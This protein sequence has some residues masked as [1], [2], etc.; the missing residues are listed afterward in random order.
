MP[1]ARYLC[2]SIDSDLR[3]ILIE[4]L[5]GQREMLRRLAVIE[6]EQRR[7]FSHMSD[8]LDRLNREVGEMRDAVNTAGTKI[9]E[10]SAE[11][12][13]LSDIVAAGGTVTDADLNAVSDQLDQMQTDLAAA[14]LPPAATTEPEPTA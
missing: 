1:D 11:I 5:G 4:F 9:G 8:A 10:Q 6:H 2:I 14:G 12:K 7:G 13:R 3:D